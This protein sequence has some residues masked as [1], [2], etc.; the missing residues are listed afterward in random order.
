MLLGRYHETELS[1]VWRKNG[2]IIPNHETTW[3]MGTICPPRSNPTY[4]PHFFEFLPID[5]V[6]PET[7]IRKYLKVR[8]WLTLS[9]N[10]SLP[11]TTQ[12]MRAGFKE[13]KLPS[14]LKAYTS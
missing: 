7:R 6:K 11:Y 3:P 5:Q 8:I 13:A 10:K 12:Y 2:Y 14:S 9:P 1:V 4:Q